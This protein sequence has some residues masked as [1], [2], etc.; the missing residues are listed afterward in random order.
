MSDYQKEAEHY[1]EV[2]QKAVDQHEEMRKKL[3]QMECEKDRAVEI[4][5][6]CLNGKMGKE[7]IIALATLITSTQK[8]IL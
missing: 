3:Y 8:P 7:D 4:A 2:A 6:D 1:K 5:L